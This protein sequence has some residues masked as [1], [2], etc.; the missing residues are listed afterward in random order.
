MLYNNT[1]HFA[2]VLCAFNIDIPQV[3]PTTL[4]TSIFNP[5]QP[6][7]AFH[8]ETIKKRPKSFL[9]FNQVTCISPEINRISD[10]FRGKIKVN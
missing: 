3:N 7:V 1:L 6:S 8:M 9:K 2:Q 4:P 5:F 10:D